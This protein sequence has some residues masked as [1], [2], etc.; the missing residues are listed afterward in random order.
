M[1]LFHFVV[2][3][4]DRKY[5]VH[6]RKNFGILN[7]SEKDRLYVAEGLLHLDLQAPDV[8][9]GKLLAKGFGDGYHDSSVG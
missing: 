3:N 5:Q 1:R 7:A 2:K 6:Y 9:A 4:F 8:L